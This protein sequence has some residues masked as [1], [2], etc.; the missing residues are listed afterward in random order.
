MRNAVVVGVMFAMSACSLYF[1]GG[2]PSATAPDA[3][4][5]AGSGSSDGSS[6][7]CYRDDAEQS[8]CTVYYAGS[9]AYFCDVGSEPN[10]QGC[11]A[12]PGSQIEC[13]CPFG[14]VCGAE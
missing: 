9:Y 8:E 12:L 6:S 7:A 5:A 11:K 14:K 4:E 13:C 1:G 10:A 3:A 2:D